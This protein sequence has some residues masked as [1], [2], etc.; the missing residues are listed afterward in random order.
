MRAAPRPHVFHTPRTLRTFALLPTYTR[1]RF[2]FAPRF[3]AQSTSTMQAIKNTI[4]ENLGIPG[5]HSLAPAENQ[6]TLDDVPDLSGKVAVLTG[7]SE[8]IGLASAHT[9][10]KHNISKLYILSP[11]ED[12]AAEAVKKFEAELGAEKA[13]RVAWVPCDLSDWAQTK[14]VAEKLRSELDRLDI[15]LNVAGRGVMSVQQNKYGIDLNM[16]VNHFGAVVL[17]S[18][19]LPVLKKTAEDP[20]NF[21]H[22]VTAGSNLHEQSP[23]ETSFADVAELNKDYGPNAQY[24]RSKLAA[25]LYARYLARHLSPNHPRV[26][27]NAFHPGV[28]DTRQSNTHIHEP[29]P[30][31]GWGNNMMYP[32]KKDIWDAACSVMYVA[33]KTEKT[34]EYVCPPAIPEPGSELARDTE[35]GE[36]LM[37][38]TREVLKTNG[39]E[40]QDY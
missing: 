8:G 30:I 11:G 24:G 21:V 32:I 9:L 25:I 35:L 13:G 17:T 19:L 28:V 15:L 5:A 31:L 6:F 38:L 37:K 18:T 23:K 33:T 7:G 12:R 16:A 40:I 36:Q 10:L 3:R 14:E 1:T 29:Y 20:S 27:A 2:T 22:I 34:G 26:L 4:A 39:F